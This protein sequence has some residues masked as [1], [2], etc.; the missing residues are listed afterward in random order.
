MARKLQ[1]STAHHYFKRSP[2]C[3]TPADVMTEALINA[4]ADT[5]PEV[6]PK[7]F[8]EFLVNVKAKTLDENRQYAIW[9][10]SQLSK[11]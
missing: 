7:T 3:Y 11:R 1:M 4:L 9:R 6:R 2:P 10:P 8:R 5:L